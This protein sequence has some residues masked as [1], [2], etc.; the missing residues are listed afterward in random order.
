MTREVRG[1]I[2]PNDV[3][4]LNQGEEVLIYHGKTM[5]LF[6]KLVEGSK[7]EISTIGEA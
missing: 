5:K 2:H 7:I 4:K 3:D 1:F 6:V